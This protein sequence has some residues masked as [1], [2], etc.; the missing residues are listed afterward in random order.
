MYRKIFLKP[1]GET[2]CVYHGSETSEA[3]SYIQKKPRQ[4]PGQPSAL[5]EWHQADR[6]ALLQRA[7]TSPSVHEATAC[8]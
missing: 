1:C 6:D 4:T 5:Q 2:S 8:R 3:G 7:L